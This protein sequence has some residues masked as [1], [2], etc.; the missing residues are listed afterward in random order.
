MIVYVKHTQIVI[1]IDRIKIEY[2][3]EDIRYTYN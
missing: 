1:Y 2:F 3:T